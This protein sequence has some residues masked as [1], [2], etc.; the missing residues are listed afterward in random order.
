MIKI[1]PNLLVLTLLVTAAAC[2]RDNKAQQLKSLDTAYQA[3]V[4]TKEEYEAKKAAILGSSNAPAAPAVEPPLQPAD[5][6][7]QSAANAPGAAADGTVPADAPPPAPAQWDASP[8]QVAP[9][10]QMAPPSQTAT[11]AQTQTAPPVQSQMPPPVRTAPSAPMPPAQRRVPSSPAP[12]TPAQP[13]LPP[14]VVQPPAASPSPDFDREE[15]EPAPTMGCED[16]EYKTHRGADVQERFFPA[17]MAAVHRAALLSMQ[18]LDFV[19]HVD[20]NHELEASKKRHFSA[21]VGAGGEKLILHFAV[22]QRGSQMGIRVT[23]ETKKSFV[24]RLSQKSWTSAVL[25][26]IAC[27]L[28]SGR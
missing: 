8:G 21:V 10:A 9:P 11:Q 14:P 4:F 19:V 16:A 6:P 23:G 12:Q 22:A 1:V 7:A 25:A 26:Q 17:S 18:N 20:A 2:H 5:P 15:P 3:G 13:P 27:N 24:G 28:R